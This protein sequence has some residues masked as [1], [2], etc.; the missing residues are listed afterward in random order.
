MAA[1]SGWLAFALI[2]LAAVVPLIAR[3]KRG[4]RATPTSAPIRGHV[5]VGLIVAGVSFLHILLA[6]VD[7]GSPSAVGAGDLALGAGALAFVVLLAHTGLGLQLRN[8]KL[9]HRKEKRGQHWITATLIAIT[10]S[11]HAYALFTAAP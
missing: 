4:K 5:V 6:V 3:L 11:A 8:P 7:L 9:R 2:P 1:W 10:V